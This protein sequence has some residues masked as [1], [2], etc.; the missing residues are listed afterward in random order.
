MRSDTA[1]RRPTKKR[2]KKKSGFG[3][4]IFVVVLI[5]ILAAGGF[6]AYKYLTAN[7]YDNESGFERFADRYFSAN[8][9]S[10]D[11]G[12]VQTEYNYGEYASSAIQYPEIG[13]E[14]VDARI[15]QLIQDEQQ[16]FRSKYGNI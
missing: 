7:N 16:S 12:D 2:R 8:V 1:R 6:A 14:N 10:D 13:L 4:F 11:I 3:C 9:E 5:V 15:S